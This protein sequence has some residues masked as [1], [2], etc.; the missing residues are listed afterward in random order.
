MRALLGEVS[1]AEVALPTL[2]PGLTLVPAEPDLAGAELDLAGLE[3]R[4]FQAARRAVALP[5]RLRVHRLS[6]QPGLADA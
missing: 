4:E 3:G 5:G 1:L 6:A 2:V